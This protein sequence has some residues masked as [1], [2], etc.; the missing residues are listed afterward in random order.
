VPVPRRVRDPPGSVAA[1]DS[2]GH[3]PLDLRPGGRFGISGE[4]RRRSRATPPPRTDDQGKLAA[5]RDLTRSGQL[6]QVA[7]R[8]AHDRFVQLGQLAADRAGSVGPAGGGQVEQR[9]GDPTG[10]LV[11]DAGPLVGRDPGEPILA[12][13]TGAGQ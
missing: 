9:C 5:G 2:R 13:P 1:G 8:A 4:H 7:Q 6:G 10:R 11:Q 3:E 12:F